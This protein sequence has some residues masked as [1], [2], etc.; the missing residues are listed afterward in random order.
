MAVKTWN[1]ISEVAGGGGGKLKGSTDVIH[2][3]QDTARDPWST[4][5][6]GTYANCSQAMMLMKVV[7]R[8]HLLRKY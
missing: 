6:R 7:S 5:V 4:L 8:A 3:G 2:A 1:A